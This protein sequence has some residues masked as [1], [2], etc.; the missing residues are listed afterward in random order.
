[1]A[2][3]GRHRHE[4]R[5]RDDRRWLQRDAIVDAALV[6][7]D[8]EGFEAVSMRRVAAELGVGTMS[9]YHHVADKDELVY[10]MADA[11]GAEMLIP[12]EVPKDWREALR[13]IA[14]HT[15][16]TF[17]RHPWLLETVERPVPT[18]NTLRHI[19]QSA[20]AVAGLHVDQAV[21]QAMVLAV[22]DYTLG[23]VL[24]ERHAGRRRQNV[25]LPERARALIEGGELPLLSRWLQEGRPMRPPPAGRFDE[26]LEWLLDGMAA[27]LER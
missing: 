17:L 9:L 26:G 21:A 1:M 2:S 23:Y 19:E 3:R 16:D 18:P 10:E 7:A 6:I 15:R 22:D 8:R 20:A 24:R 11:I 25:V 27:A 13:Q 14:L 5:P 12:G 4:P